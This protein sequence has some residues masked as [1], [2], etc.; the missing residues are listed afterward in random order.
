MYVRTYILYIHTYIH[1]TQV[2]MHVYALHLPDECRIHTYICM[3]CTYIHTQ[4]KYIIM[5]YVVSYRVREVCM[6]PRLLQRV[7]LAHF[8]R[9]NCCHLLSD[10]TGMPGISLPPQHHIQYRLN[11]VHL[12]NVN[13]LTAG[14][15]EKIGIMG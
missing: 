14:C 3:V 15:D 12:N 10:V 13:K 2:C 6:V 11:I 8:G 5:E 4:I 1:I 9:C 7:R